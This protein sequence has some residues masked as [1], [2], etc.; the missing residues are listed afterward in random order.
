MTAE[1]AAQ[2][3]LTAQILPRDAGRATLIAR[4]WDPDCDAARVAV[5]RG[6]TLVDISSLALSV[7]ELLEG[8]AGELLERI[9]A[10][11]PARSWPLKA[12]L[13]AS[14]SAETNAPHLLAPIDLQV[15][16][17]CGVTFVDS[18][19][20]RVIEERCGGDPAKA[21]AVRA[22]V[23]AALGGDIADLR[24]GS[25]AAAEVKQVL[26]EQGI[27]S[28]YLEVGIGPDPEVFTKAP[29]LSSVGYGADIG[30]PGFSSWNNPEPELVLVVDSRGVI[31]G[32]TLGNDVNLRDV[33][34]R[35]SLL[36]GMAKDNNA[37]SAL[38]P[39]VRLFDENF[40]VESLRNE[41]ITLRV[42]GADGY[43]MAG[44]NSVGRISRAFEE[45]VG[46]AHGEHHQYPDGFVL[47]TGTLF[48]P[49][50]DRGVP[51]LGFTHEHGD[52]VTI[53][54]AQL[55]TLENVVR[56]TESLR[57]WTVGI[58]EFFAGRERVAAALRP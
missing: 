18:M 33:E 43:E 53:S 46:A 34:G 54:S 6:N 24:P 20:E 14:R 8:T 37:S 11:V 2:Q 39:F 30:I 12:V 47:Y 45:L 49:K 16:K 51:G 17:A 31:R 19:V 26:I 4:V 38:G 15:V 5:V 1:T 44:V 10:V 28:A 41:E 25:P 35:S 55:G 57:P 13:E 21:A 56:P 40:T 48:A 50:E 23:T 22:Q 27:W 58:R 32:A 29:V 36:L 7:T 9:R 42:E 3:S 52:R